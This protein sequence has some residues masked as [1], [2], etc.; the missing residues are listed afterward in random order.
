[1]FILNI[2]IIKLFKK[3]MKVGVNAS[4]LIELIG[5]KSEK[6]IFSRT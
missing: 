3:L 6:T 5:Y 4:D 2:K 1:M